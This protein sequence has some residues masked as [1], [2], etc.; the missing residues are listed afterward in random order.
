MP[1]VIAGVDEAGRGPLAGPV[2]AAAV[3]LPPRL[4]IPGLKDSKQLTPKERNY[5][6]ALLQYKALGIGVGV[7]DSEE[8]DRLNIFHATFKA[9][10][11]AV[12]KLPIQPNKIFVD[13]NHTIANLD[14]PQKAVVKGDTFHTSIMCASVIAKVSRDR[15][16]EALHQ[17]Y[18]HYGFHRHKG[19]GTAM[20]LKAL[21]T[22]GPCPIHRRSFAPVREALR[23]GTLPEVSPDRTAMFGDTS[24]GVPGQKISPA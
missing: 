12:G 17:Q 16:M 11:I 5:F 8:I 1:L 20:H 15:I 22:H 3:I 24:G 9:M 7:I 14:I 21:Q 19:Y 4:K 6:F 23:L 2:V 18:P 13:G 10:A